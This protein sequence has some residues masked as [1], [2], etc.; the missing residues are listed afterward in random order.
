ML[1]V[2]RL[3]VADA[4]A[5][6]NPLMRAAMSMAVPPDVEVVLSAIEAIDFQALANDSVRT[7]VLLRDVPAA[8]AAHA[9]GLPKGLLNVG[10]VHA[11]AGRSQVTRSVFLTD[12]E[13]EQL[14]R[15]SD[16][17]MEVSMQAVPAEAALRLS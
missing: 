1:R 3:V 8:V 10:N 15:L 13:R 5:A 4:E 17:G 16:E 7:M 9:R 2:R 11:G 12:E 14:R 6:R